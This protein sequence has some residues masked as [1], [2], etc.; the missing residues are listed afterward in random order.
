MD[1]KGM[2][3]SPRMIEALRGL[4]YK[5]A[6]PVQGRA[7]PAALRGE[8][9]LVQSATGTGK[10][11]SFLIPLIERTDLSLPRLQSIVISP[12]AELARQTYEFAREFQRYFPSFKARLY[13]AE[14]EV[15]QNVEGKEVPPHMAIGTPGR[16][17][18]ILLSRS[19]FSLRNVRNLVL[20]EA[21]MLLDMNFMGEV[22]AL[23][24]A[25]PPKC[26][27]L[28]FSAT[29]R[30]NLRDALSKFVRE[31][32]R[33]EAEET[34][35]ASGVRHHV[36]DIGHMGAMNALLQLLR[37]KNPYLALVFCL[38][39]KEDDSGLMTACIYHDHL[40]AWSISQEELRLLAMKNTPRHF[41]PVITN[42]SCF[43]ENDTPSG[44]G[45]LKRRQST[46]PA[47]PLYVLTNTSGIHGASCMLYPQVLKNFAEGVERDLIILPSSI[48]EVLLLPFFFA[49][50]FFH[51]LYL[52][53]LWL[54]VFLILIHQMH[55]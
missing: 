55:L 24:K 51:G 36:V 23:G 45:P 53:Y 44:P 9:L 26:A 16:L 50:R 13:T 42:M 39:L 33:Y 41:P 22:E 5:N 2:N 15:S 19:L 34:R 11:H 6:S 1:F 20:D 49:P 14:D 48:H 32:F 29:L 10:T 30:Q 40:E 37:I 3:L 12:T 21:D 28:V 35:T 47:S 7:I 4:G 17:K 38:C 52:L 31:D 18:D 27:F 43:L 8:S 54:Q 46:V 25:L